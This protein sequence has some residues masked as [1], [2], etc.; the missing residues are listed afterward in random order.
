MRPC[1]STDWP[2]PDLDL[3]AMGQ[4]IF[5]TPNQ[6]FIEFVKAEAM[7]LADLHRLSDAQTESLARLMQA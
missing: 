5:N 1:N 7:P 4:I 2:R 3:K 6:M